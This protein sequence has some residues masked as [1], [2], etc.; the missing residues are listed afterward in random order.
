MRPP[1]WVGGFAY[2][3]EE[4]DGSRFVIAMDLQAGDL[5]AL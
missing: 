3:G 4:A 2:A 1:R 5:R